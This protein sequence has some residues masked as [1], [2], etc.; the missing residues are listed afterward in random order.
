MPFSL[1]FLRHFLTK[2][3]CTKSLLRSSNFVLLISFSRRE[4]FFYSLAVAYGRHFLKVCATP[5]HAPACWHSCGR[6]RKLNANRHQTLTL[7][8]CE[9]SKQG[10]K[11][12]LDLILH[13]DS[14]S[15]FGI[16]TDLND[17]RIPFPCFYTK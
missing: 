11:N 14:Q 2:F 3:T 9:K 6:A 5:I 4:Y 16:T 8:S 17:E 12:S 13:P 7:V 15:M 1:I 10:Q